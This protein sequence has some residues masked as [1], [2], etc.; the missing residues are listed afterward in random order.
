MSFWTAFGAKFLAFGLLLVAA[1]LARKLILPLI[2]EG[3]V[4]GLLTREIG[5]SRSPRNS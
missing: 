1:L 5:G 4:K 2:P 3:R